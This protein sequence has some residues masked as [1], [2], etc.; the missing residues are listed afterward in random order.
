MDVVVGA[1]G[2]L[3]RL[4]TERL[5]ASGAEVV[6]AGRPCDRLEQ[7]FDARVRVRKLDL[8]IEESIDSALRG[9]RRVIATAHGRDATT[10][11]GPRD[12]DLVGYERLIR[13]CER[14]GVRHMVFVS[15]SSASLESPVD[16]FRYKAV[17][18]IR[19]RRSQIPFTILRPTHLTE[20]WLDALARDMP[21]NRITVPGQG[22][23]PSRFVAVA[24]VAAAIESVLG[25][26]GALGLS[27]PVVG[28]EALTVDQVALILQ[29][30]CRTAP[31]IRHVRPPLLR[32]AA[33]LTAPVNPLFSRHVR[34]TL[35]LDTAAT[36]P[37]SAAEIA[38]A[39]RFIPPPKITVAEVIAATPLTTV[40][41]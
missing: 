3:G 11:R 6:A 13:A 27:L 16:C 28:P 35:A 12:V 32:L 8:T 23:T 26:P 38:Q 17:T 9:A 22:R 39:W 1:A 18:E 37:P 10:R 20:V 15:T 36:P 33:T 21:K 30:N 31:V 14:H 7:L 19:L 5:A 34:M 41:N 2:R 25:H 4:V 24:D 29:R 40:P